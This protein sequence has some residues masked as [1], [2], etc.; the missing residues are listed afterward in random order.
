MPPDASREPAVHPIGS[1]LGVPRHPIDV[2]YNVST[3]ANGCPKP[4]L[5]LRG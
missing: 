5:R 3:K 4:D 1:A 2:F